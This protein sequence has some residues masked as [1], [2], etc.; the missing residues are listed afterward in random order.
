VACRV[1]NLGTAISA[2]ALLLFCAMP[3]AMEAPNPQPQPDDAPAPPPPRAEVT[4]TDETQFYEKLQR[5]TSYRN[6]RGLGVSQ[7]TITALG[8][9]QIDVAVSTLGALA[10]QGNNKANIALVRI[11]HFCGRVTSSRPIDP[12]TQMAN[13]PELPPQRAARVAGVMRA[14]AEWMARARAACVKAPFDYRGIEGRLRESAA[15]GDPASATEL[16]QYVRDPAQRKALLQSAL[17]KK[18]PQAYYAVATELLMAVQRG[19]TTENVG[20]IREYLKQ[21]GRSV[22][23]AKIDLA[24]C[25]ALGCDGHPADAATAQAFGVDAARDAEPTAFVAMLRMPWGGNMTRK[26]LL[27]WQYFGDRLN[28]EGCLGDTYIPS[29]ASFSQAIQLLE[30]GQPPEALESARQLGDDLWRDNSARAK[31][32]NNCG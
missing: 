15:A 19:Q 5:V 21:A 10:S 26:Q 2:A 30:N 14:E 17:D 3:R 4:P 27:A 16:A 11:Q 23:K 28:E 1:R 12:K 25:M 18:Y 22:T 24:N 13:L 9:G 32:E 20:S 6:L 8:R 31:K 7:D 29:T